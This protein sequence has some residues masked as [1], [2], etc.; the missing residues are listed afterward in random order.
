MQVGI[1][2]STVL[3]GVAACLLAGAAAAQEY[4]TKAVR[5]VVPFGPGGTTDQIARPYADHLSKAFGQPFVIE[6]KG[7]ASGQIGSEAVAK[8]A[9]DGY[10][11]LMTPQAPL[12][13]VP[14]LRKT[15][16]DTVKDFASIGRLGDS[17]SGLAVHPSMPVN[18]FK[19]FV[20]YVKARPGDILYGSGGLG[21][22]QHIRGEMLNH[23]LGLKMV[24][25][26]YA[27]SGEAMAALLA[28]Q[29][30]MQSESLLIPQVR[31]GKLKLLAFM[32][33]RGL[34]EFPN[35]PTIRDAGWP[36]YDLPNWYAAFAPA[37]T[38]REIIAKL[39]A[40]IVK[41]ARSPEFEKQMELL[42]WGMSYDTPEEMD[43]ILR[44]DTAKFARYIKAANITVN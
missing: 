12:I 7:G 31:A 20:D 36:D 5:V 11:I 19:E 1:R 38:P 28:N 40:E 29:I 44:E 3:C 23:L 15:P 33:Q 42:A 4:P 43:R 14:N 10:T 13:I 32:E 30:H 9:P 22:A 26:P 37:G 27:N 35:V 39:N 24:H 18:N 6:N 25:V 17:I 8:A 34:R 21:T 41:L 2:L 16:Y